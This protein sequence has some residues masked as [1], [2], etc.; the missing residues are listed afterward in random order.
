[1]Y[2]I[3]C[4]S[5][6]KGQTTSLVLAR[7]SFLHEARCVLHRFQEHTEYMVSSV[8][9]IG[10]PIFLHSP[11]TECRL[12]LYDK[13]P[14]LFS[15]ETHTYIPG[16]V[17]EVTERVNPR[18]RASGRTA[19][20]RETME[21]HA[22]CIYTRYIYNGNMRSASVTEVRGE[23]LAENWFTAA[24]VSTVDGGVGSRQIGCRR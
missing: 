15:G 19:R 21:L 16:R 4:R 11:N 3:F 8:C 1:M 23:V 14:Q 9:E 10:E 24:T 2:D 20:E 17:K 6:K 7:L 5:S 13:V 22:T 18:G 12:E